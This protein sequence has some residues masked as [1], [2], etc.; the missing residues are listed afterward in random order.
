[1][2]AKLVLVTNTTYYFYIVHAQKNATQYKLHTP[3]PDAA[4]L[5]HARHA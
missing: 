1:M 2:P 5:S 3:F 4:M